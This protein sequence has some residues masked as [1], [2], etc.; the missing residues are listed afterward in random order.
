MSLVA[1][2]KVSK[3]FGARDIVEDANWAIEDMRRIGFIEQGARKNVRDVVGMNR[4]QADGALALYRTKSFNDRARWQTESAIARH[5]DCDQIAINGA[6]GAIGR[7]RHLA[8]ELFLVDR[9]QPAAAAGQPAKNTEH[10]M[11][12]AV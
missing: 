7:D 5:L 9:H 8:A 6:Q 2:S 4:D 12:C 11:F 1:F 10:A 3:F